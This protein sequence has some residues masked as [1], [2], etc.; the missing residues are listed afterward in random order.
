[1]K[2]YKNL[3]FNL[4]HQKIFLKPLIEENKNLIQIIILNENKV[5]N[6]KKIKKEKIKI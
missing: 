4:Y 1:M 2:I 3:W 6:V 5:R